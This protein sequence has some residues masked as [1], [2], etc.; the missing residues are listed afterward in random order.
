[1]CGIF[2]SIPTKLRAV[3]VQNMGGCH[4]VRPPMILGWS[5]DRGVLNRQHAEYL[6]C[7]GSLSDE[8]SCR[9]HI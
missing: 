3:G 9:Q 4:L 5:Y 2:S 8:Y 6:M 7:K 1:M